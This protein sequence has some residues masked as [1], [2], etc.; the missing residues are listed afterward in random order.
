MF[1]LIDQA[2]RLA[3][4]L[5]SEAEMRQII[6]PRRSQHPDEWFV[7]L[8]WDMNWDGERGWY[9]TMV[10]ALNRHGDLAENLERIRSWL[11]RNKN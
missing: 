11:N 7:E 1:L 8:L 9:E 4:E 6:H 3:K 10:T 2:N 5:P